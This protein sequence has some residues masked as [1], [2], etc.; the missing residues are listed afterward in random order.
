MVCCSMKSCGFYEGE[1]E[2]CTN[3][4][5]AINEQGV[6]IYIAKYFNGKATLPLPENKLKINVEVVE[7][8]E[9][10]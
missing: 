9:K 10:R 7:D 2:V 6:C 5:L 8:D 3:P 1:Y 4:Y